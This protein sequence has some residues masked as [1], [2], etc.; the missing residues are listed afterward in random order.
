MP[1]SLVDQSTL[2]SR[3]VET[4]RAYIRVAIGEMKYKEAASIASGGRRKGEAGKPVTIGS[5]FRTV[6]QARE[7]IRKS[8]VTLLIG[9]WLGLVKLED[10]RRL[11]DTA[12]GDV[13]NLS[14]EEADRF[15]VVLRALVK[16]IVM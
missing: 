9:I 8:I 1:E 14:E 11:L 2:T 12:G 5:Y 4:L 7:N 10:V 13:T 16:K 15:E 6:Q 3:Q